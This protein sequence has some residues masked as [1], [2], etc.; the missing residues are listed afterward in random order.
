MFCSM[1]VSA[2]SDT[3]QPFD[4]A[5]RNNSSQSDGRDAARVEIQE[6][7]PLG[8]DLEVAADVPR[9]AH[10]GLRNRRA[11]HP[12]ERPRRGP[13]V[14]EIL[15]HQGFHALLRLPALAAEHLGDFFLQ[16]VGQHVH[17]ARALEVQ[18]RADA[19]EELLGVLQLTRGTIVLGV[20]A[21]RL[22][23][24]D[25]PRGGNVAQPARRAL[26]VRLQLVDR[27]VERR[28]PFVDELQQRV[29]ELPPVV[30]GKAAH[31]RLEPLKEALVAGNEPDVEQGEQELG[32]AEIELGEVG[33]L[34]HVLTDGQPQIPERL[35][36][37]ADEALLARR[38]RILEE[39]QQVDVGVEAERSP[40]VPAERAN[41]HG[42][43]GVRPRGFRELLH[44]RVDAARVAGLHVAPA[45][46][47][48]RRGDVFLSGLAK[49]GAG[50]RL[51][52]FGQ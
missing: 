5:I 32:V 37:R 27:V 35:E 46:P 47:V 11:P 20:G 21:A 48:P 31:P 26:D 24:P 43:A 39:D 14:P 38:H 41:R 50:R 4:S 29:E 33:D 44:Q 30:D 3:A 45:A 25:V 52:P 49:H 23:H 42:R 6:T 28:M 15:P 10:P 17:V 22:Q 7:D 9:D 13:R 8:G 12:A 40:A 18:D 1:Q 34:P 51:V 19:L 2:C 16:L 36:E